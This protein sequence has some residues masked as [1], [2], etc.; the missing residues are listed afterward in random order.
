[1]DGLSTEIVISVSESS[2]DHLGIEYYFS[3]LKSGLPVELW[4]QPLGIGLI[5]GV[6]VSVLVNIVLLVMLLAA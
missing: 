2:K 5:A 4:Q 6:A 1:M 3:G